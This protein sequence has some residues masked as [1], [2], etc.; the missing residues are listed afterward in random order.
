[1]LTEQISIHFEKQRETENAECQD[2][3]QLVVIKNPFEL[4][5]RPERQLA[6]ALSLSGSTMRWVPFLA[7][8]EKTNQRAEKN[9]ERQNTSLP[10]DILLRKH[11]LAAG[12]INNSVFIK[13][14]KT[15]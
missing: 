2:G 10:G 14:W 9:N 5:L 11:S 12:L 13:R 4:K 1:M 8:L 15:C 7:Q 6:E 3:Q